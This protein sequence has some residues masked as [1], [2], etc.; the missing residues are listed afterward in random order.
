M[1]CEIHEYILSLGDEILQALYLSKR[2]DF[3]FNLN[4]LIKQSSTF[5][6][7][8]GMYKLLKSDQR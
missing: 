8:C 2:G 5:H 1:V 3:N 4:Q 6:S 7:S